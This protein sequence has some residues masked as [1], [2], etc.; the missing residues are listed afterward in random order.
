MPYPVA[1]SLVAWTVG[2]IS[3]RRHLTIPEWKT[4]LWWSFLAVSPDFDFA[5]SAITGDYDLHRTGTH[6]L[7]TAA[8]VG[9]LL[10]VIEFRAFN[11]RRGLLY[12]A[13][14][15]SHA[16]LDWSTTRAART[17]GPAL[18]WPISN[19]RYALGIGT[20]PEISIPGVPVT[21]QPVFE[22]VQICLVELLIFLPVFLLIS[23]VI[24]YFRR[25]QSI[26]AA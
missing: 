22:L 24:S 9:M 20:L 15:G 13:L 26:S 8:I 2:I 23:L 18:F 11:W 5:V 16:M 17:S 14:I 4:A 1:H 3:R 7:I 25:T 10:A 21:L 19:Q 12:S 6:S